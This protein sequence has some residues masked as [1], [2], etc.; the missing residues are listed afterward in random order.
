VGITSKELNLWHEL[1]L[2][3][4][5]CNVSRRLWT[6]K[7]D[8]N[9]IISEPP[10]Y[11]KKINLRWQHGLR[12][13]IISEPW[14]RTLCGIQLFMLL[15]MRYCFDNSLFSDHII[16]A[17]PAMSDELLQIK[18]CNHGGR[19]NQN[20]G[21]MWSEQKNKNRLGEDQLFFS[22]FEFWYVPLEHPMWCVDIAVACQNP[23]AS[24]G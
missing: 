10:K 5:T 1:K 22:E 23:P 17:E 24:S 7:S 4:T 8:H 14:G 2:I 6:L 18:C 19:M 12:P 13:A 16:Y 11:Q 15:S 3:P 21:N 20:Q 9:T